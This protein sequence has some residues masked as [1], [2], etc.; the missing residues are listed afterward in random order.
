[1]AFGGRE[2]AQRLGL[3][4]VLRDAGGHLVEETV[5]YGDGDDRYLGL[6]P[7]TGPSA[8]PDPVPK[9][10]LRLRLLK[11]IVRR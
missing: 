3:Y 4:E 11:G 7:L 5:N 6:E 9:S 1:M 8:A 2:Q 10:G